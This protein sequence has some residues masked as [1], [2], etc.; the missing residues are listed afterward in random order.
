M[1]RRL[2]AQKREAILAAIRA[3]AGWRS[4]NDIAR[5]HDVSAATVG[6][7]AAEAGVTDA[8]DRTH[9]ARASQA[10]QVDNRAR[11]AALVQ[12]YLDDAERIRKRLWEPA[13][14]VTATGQV[15]SL[16]LPQGRDVRDFAMAGTA[17]VKATIEVE[18]HDQGDQGAEDAKS[19]LLG[20]AEGL[21]AMYA[22]SVMADSDDPDA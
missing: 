11:R 8:F 20:V 19:M 14:Q 1:P 3:G 5:E 2:D 15:V 4:R 6:N 22:A 12:A 9:L 10:K 13:E 7:I 18:K 17:L 21:K 16:T